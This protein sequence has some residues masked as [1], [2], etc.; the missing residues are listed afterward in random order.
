MMDKAQQMTDRQPLVFVFLA[1]SFVLR[2]TLHM[3]A[4]FVR[5]CFC[6]ALF[7]SSCFAAFLSV[8]LVNV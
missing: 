8:V 3:T 6:F 7:L 5:F 2:Q 4:S 1:R